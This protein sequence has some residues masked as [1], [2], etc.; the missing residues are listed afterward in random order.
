MRWVQSRCQKMRP[1]SL[2][3]QERSLGK[4]RGMNAKTLQSGI[5]EDTNA[6][7]QARFWCPELHRSHPTI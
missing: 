1:P 4:A 5:C 6:T 2:T 3:V 7:D